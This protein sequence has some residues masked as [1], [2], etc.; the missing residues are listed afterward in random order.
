MALSRRSFIALGATAITSSG[1]GII[2]NI[3]E[4]NMVGIVTSLAPRGWF[5]KTWEGEMALG[6][7]R[8]GRAGGG[9]TS[10]FDFH[11]DDQAVYDQLQ[12]AMQHITP[13][14]I[15]YFET[16]GHNYF[17]RESSNTVTAVKDL[18]AELVL[19]ASPSLSHSETG[20]VANEEAPS[21]VDAR[22]GITLQCFPAP[23]TAT[24][25]K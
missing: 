15:T 10:T 2:T 5:L 12:K 18:S 25:P 19:P 7:M 4:G 23:T 24:G 14:E 17:T 11:V 16:L 6:N 20:P 9:T 1:C 21:G 22:K 13:V 3:N 8:A